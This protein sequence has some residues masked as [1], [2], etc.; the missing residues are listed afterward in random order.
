VARGWHPESAE[1]HILMLTQ[2]MPYVSIGT[3]SAGMRV[4]DWGCNSGYGVDTMNQCGA[5]AA[6]LDISPR[7]VRAAR[8]RLPHLQSAIRLYNGRTFPFGKQRFPVITCFQTLE[9]VPDPELPHLF[10]HVGA[11]LADGGIA[12]FTTPNAARRSSATG[13]PWNPFHWREYDAARLAALLTRRFRSVTVLGLFGTS[14]LLAIDRRRRSACRAILGA[15]KR[16]DSNR[17]HEEACRY[18]QDRGGLQARF[19]PLDTA[20]SLGLSDLWFDD[21]SL[22]R[23]IDLLAICGERID[24]NRHISN[25]LAHP[26]G[27]ASHPD[28]RTRRQRATGAGGSP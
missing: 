8:A 4:L 27:T 7:A 15:A 23:A 10:N 21:R 11:A 14:R 24:Q 12:V 16:R 9:H 25:W 18:L 3:Y 6:G 13:R 1:E 19:R 26:L 5:F 2:M 22:S 28:L 17:A 20:M